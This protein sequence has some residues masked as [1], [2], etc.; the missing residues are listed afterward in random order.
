V[1]RPRDRV[2]VAQFLGGLCA[3]LFLALLIL[4]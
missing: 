3:I 4:D 2:T 1:V